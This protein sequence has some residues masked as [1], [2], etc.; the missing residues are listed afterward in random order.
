MIKKR[1]IPH[2]EFLQTFD[3]QKQQP[4]YNIIGSEVYLVDQ[5][6]QKI[7]DKFK[8]PGAEEFDF[9]T[10]YGDVNSGSQILEQLE[11]LPFLAKHKLVLI[12]RFDQMKVA[13]KNII[14]EYLENPAP[15]SILIITSE[16]V[17][18]RSNAGKIIAEYAVNIICRS[19]YNPE[20]IARWLRIEIS[21]KKITMDNE[22]IS[23]FA[24]SIPLEYMIAANEL[25]KLII[26]TRNKGCI[27]ASDVKETIGHTKTDKVFDLQNAVGSRNL[28]NSLIVLDNII[29]NEE[30]S[31][32]AVFIIMMLTR[33]F[34]HLWKVNSLRKKSISDSEIESRYL[35][36]V[37]FKFR[38]DYLGFADKYSLKQIRRAFSLLLQADTDAKSLNVKLEIILHTLIYK[39]VKIT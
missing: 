24:G 15:T 7:L 33:F 2:Y 1:Q 26:F 9:I 31:K 8:T 37:F 5:V 34:T 36:D 16:K 6:L 32:V 11:M 30:P 21:K 22:A 29:T 38:K 17:D 23:I 39:L 19:P 35:T 14:A 25:E 12:K 3:R 28:K 13:D 27:T 20:D 18:G 4:A 10:F